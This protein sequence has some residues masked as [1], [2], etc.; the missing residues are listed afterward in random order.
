MIMLK[1]DKE[2]VIQKNQILIVK[3][4]GV[5]KTKPGMFELTAKNIGQRQMLTVSQAADYLG[6]HVNTVRRWTETGLIKCIR[7]GGRNDR[8]F[9]LEELERIRLSPADTFMQR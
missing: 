6:L 2:P 7:V 4:T 5:K 1:L 8:R 9:A 3:V